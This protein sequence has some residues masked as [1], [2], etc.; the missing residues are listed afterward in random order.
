VVKGGKNRVYNN[1]CFANGASDILLFSGREVDKWWQKW[2]K[3]Y[4][5][6]NEDSLLVNNCAQVIVS[7]RGRRDPGLPGDHSNNYTGS[8]PKLVDPE[9]LDFR[10]RKDSPLVDAGRVVEGVTAP[11]EG[12]APDIGAYE[13]GADPWLPGHRNSVCVT[14]RAQDELQVALG[15]PILRPITLTVSAGGGTLAKLTFTPVDWMR[16][17][18]LSA[19]GASGVA[20]LRFH[21]PEWGEAVVANLQELAPLQEARAPFE[22][23]DLSSATDVAPRFYYEEVYQP[24]SRLESHVRAFRVG[25][26]VVIDGRLS[27]KEWPSRAAERW[28]PL[29]RPQAARKGTKT[30]AG[31]AHAVGAAC[32][33][34]DSDN[35]YV[36]FQVAKV[37]NSL[38]SRFRSRAT[39]GDGAAVELAFRPIVRKRPGPVY[40]LRGDPSG[41]FESLTEAGASQ[42][43][44]RNLKNAVRYGAHVGRRSWSAEFAIPW[45]ALGGAFADVEFFQINVAARAPAGS[46]RAWFCYGF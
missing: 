2:V 13:F 8:V 26:P 3:A 45:K 19:K 46:N 9:H 16:P 29:T 25:S 32:F 27:P 20:R 42:E 1:T 43:Q 39:S 4:E 30:T 37:A 28:L 33:L 17:Q 7:T 6:Q 41:R 38:R 18:R 34:F 15:M 5:H 40:V 36:A 23:P 22:R 31:T 35:L 24:A 10:P 14:R 11:F 21:C 44:A 12:R